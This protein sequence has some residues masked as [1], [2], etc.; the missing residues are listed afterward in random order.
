MSLRRFLYL[1]SQPR[2]IFSA[3]I[4]SPAHGMGSAPVDLNVPSGGP[5]PGILPGSSA[6]S[7]KG[8]NSERIL[9]LRLSL[10]VFSFSGQTVHVEPK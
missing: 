10:I 8:M 3:M 5:S 4:E 1:N 6:A 9:A 2:A 7:A